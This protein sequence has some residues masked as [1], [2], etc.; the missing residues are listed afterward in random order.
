[1]RG[2]TSLRGAVVNRR[3]AFTGSPFCYHVKRGGGRS[4]LIVLAARP[5]RPGRRVRRP[6]RPLGAL[7]VANVPTTRLMRRRR[8]AI[9]AQPSETPRKDPRT[10]KQ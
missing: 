10:P 1:M 6:L 4:P 7:I 9:C 3:P 8:A 2:G 5:G